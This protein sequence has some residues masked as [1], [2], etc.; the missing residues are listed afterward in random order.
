MIRKAKPENMAKLEGFYDDVLEYLNATHNYPGWRKDLHPTMEE[1]FKS[2]EEDCLYLAFA[3]ESIAASMV[4]DNH[5]DMEGA[6]VSWQTA[7]PAERI[8]FIHTLA[9]H[10]EHMKRGL[11][12]S[13]VRF[14]E[15]T[16]AANNGAA[17][18]LNV[19]KGNEPA[20]RLY[21]KCGFRYIDTVSLG[22]ERYGLPWFEVYE[23]VL[24]QSV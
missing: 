10:P 23:K 15:E 14:A 22:Y 19:L 21:K 13:F 8:Y 1:A 11:G 3:D 24:I 5:S 2:M 17:I 6:C 7:A 16:A 18:R 20:V 4:L 9:V 12:E